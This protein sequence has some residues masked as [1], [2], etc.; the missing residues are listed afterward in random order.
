LLR[1]SGAFMLNRVDFR[2]GYE[3]EQELTQ[4]RRASP[5]I[6]LAIRRMSCQ[7]RLS[8]VY[9]GHLRCGAVL[10]GLQH[11]TPVPQPVNQSFLGASY[12]H[13]GVVCLKVRESARNAPLA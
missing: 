7:M 10:F 2:P 9:R 1:L 3:T 12:G 6:K 13:L 8:A 11:T 4:F 5:L